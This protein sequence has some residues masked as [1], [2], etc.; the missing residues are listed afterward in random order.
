MDKQVYVVTEKRRG[1]FW[2][3]V[4]GLVVGALGLWA[5]NKY[6]NSKNDTQ[7]VEDV[8]SE[9]ASHPSF[10]WVEEVKMTNDLIDILKNKTNRTQRENDILESLENKLED[11]YSEF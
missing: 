9:E 10:N 4:G 1:G 5:V 7:E 2:P 11:L 8:E 3:F 6:Q